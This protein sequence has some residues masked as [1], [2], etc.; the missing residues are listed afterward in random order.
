MLCDAL[1]QGAG[2]VVE[3]PGKTVKEAPKVDIH[4]RLVEIGLASHLPESTWPFAS[5]V[6]EVAGKVAALERKGVKN[7]FIDVELKKSACLL[8]HH[9]APPCPPP[10][11]PLLRQVLAEVLSRLL[12]SIGGRCWRQ[13]GAKGSA[14]RA[15]AP[16][17]SQAY[18][19]LGSL[20]ACAYMRQG[21]VELQA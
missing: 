11:P 3:D 18:L 2:H 1:L 6:R 20:L 13:R 8:A 4:A 15:V 19:V 5:A 12:P 16:Q 21:C 7:A 10:P 14:E 17:Q 9:V